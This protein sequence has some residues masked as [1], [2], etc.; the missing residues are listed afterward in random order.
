MAPRH[1]NG[2]LPPPSTL[3]YKIRRPPKKSI[4]SILKAN[5]NPAK[6]SRSRRAGHVPPTLLAAS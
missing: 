6:F 2:P 5:D 3:N 1:G 4:M